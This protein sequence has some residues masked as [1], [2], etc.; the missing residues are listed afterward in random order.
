[1]KKYVNSKG[2]ELIIRP[3]EEPD[4]ERVLEI[5]EL[6]WEPIYDGYRKAMGEELFLAFYPDWRSSK[7]AHIRKIMRSGCGFVTLI[8]G[9]VVGFCS[10][11]HEDGAQTGTVMDNAVHPDWRGNGIGAMQNRWILEF[12][13]SRGVKYV[14]VHTG[15]DDAH[16]PARKTYE[17]VGF[18]RSI[19]N[20]VYYQELK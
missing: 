4:M 8:E 6:A 19:P 20:V 15:L 9:N 3:F 12:L 16:A 11:A 13:R 1:M 17:R 10:Y 2:E 14:C 5:A 18:D 7:R